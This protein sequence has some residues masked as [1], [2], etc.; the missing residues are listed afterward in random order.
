MKTVNIY[1]FTRKFALKFRA[2]IKWYVEN[3]GEN[4]YYEKILGSMIY[5]RECDF[6]VVTVP[7]EMWCEI[8]NMDDLVRARRQFGE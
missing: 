3:M 6:R 7:E 2:L 4:S 1:K 5:Y 8:D